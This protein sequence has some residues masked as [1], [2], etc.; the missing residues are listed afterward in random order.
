ME[1]DV[2]KTI[3]FTG[4]RDFRMDEQELTEK[5]TKAIR[6]EYR[7]GFRVFITGMAQGFDLLAAEAVIELK[8]MHDNILLVCAIPFRGQENRYSPQDKQRYFMVLNA[9]DEAEYL[10]EG[11]YDGCFLRRND[12]MLENS[13]ALIAHFDDSKKSGTGYTIRRAQRAGKQVVNLI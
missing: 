8:K 13:S 7:N 4:H 9:A 11:Y 5:L 1:F 2:S 10:S 6:E 3:A 12:Y